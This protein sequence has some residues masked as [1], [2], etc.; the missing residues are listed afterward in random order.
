MVP[1]AC[2]VLSLSLVLCPLGL[3]R[4]WPYAVSDKERERGGI[5]LSPLVLPSPASCFSAFEITQSGSDAYIDQMNGPEDVSWR[6]LAIGADWY[7]AEC[8]NEVC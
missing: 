5:P 4:V 1:W 2:A 6:Y 7:A 3:K 8:V